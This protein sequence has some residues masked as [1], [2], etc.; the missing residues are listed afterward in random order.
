MNELQLVVTKN[1]VGQ[2]ET[3]I[4]ALETFVSER[5]KAYSPELYGG[6][7]VTAKKDRAELN[8]AKTQ[9]AESRKTLMKELMKPYADFETRCKA[10]EKSIELASGKLDE[11]VKFKEQE[12]KDAKKNLIVEM[13]QSK[14]FDLVP[15]EKVFNVKWLN[16]TTKLTE[17]EKEI[18][19][20]ISKIYSDLKMIDRFA[21]DSETVKA[22][23]LD[24][25]DIGSALDFGEQLLKN[26]Q[27]VAEEAES[28]PER[29]HEAHMDKQREEL[30]ADAEVVNAKA[31][32]SSLVADALE[33]ERPKATVSEYVISVNA[34]ET[35]IL[36]IRNFLTMQEIEINSCEKLEF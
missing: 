23:Y 22:Y 2:L 32:R 17:V 21:D 20:T 25:L 6:D 7:A 29:E 1:I 14:N 4:E 12:E 35:Q 36:A 3:N 28:R 27:K 33:V 9:I 26:R 19:A 13:W 11:I 18:D 34:T 15:I 30:R 5:L 8:S 10:L 31:Q 24:C 16:K